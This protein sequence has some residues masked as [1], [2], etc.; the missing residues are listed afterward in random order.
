M[1]TRM[2][3]SFSAAVYKIKL[4]SPHYEEI[5]MDF[6]V[7]AHMTTV[8]DL[9]MYSYEKRLVNFRPDEMKFLHMQLVMEPKRLLSSYPI[10]VLGDTIRIIKIL[11]TGFTVDMRVSATEYSEFLKFSYPDQNSV[12]FPINGEIVLKFG[13]SAVRNIQ[14]FVPA[15]VD[16]NALL[17]SYG[18][19]MVRNLG[20]LKEAKKRGYVAW[21]D[22]TFSQRAFLLELPSDKKANS[23]TDRFRFERIR[24]TS[25]GTLNMGYRDGDIHSWQRYTTQIPLL[26]S[27]VDTEEDDS[28]T[29]NL[30]SILRMKPIEELKYNTC[31]AILLSNNVPTVPLAGC[32]GDFTGFT[33]PGTT[34]D[35]IIA[36]KTAVRSI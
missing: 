19:N 29:G 22:Q 30:I 9:M 25:A 34:E 16:K 13:P 4:I 23:V 12:D 8:Y 33:D 7:Y 35:H 17:T 27:L 14:I 11:N 31:Y 24:Y 36:F 21:T 18:G 2:S 15:L 10:D 1:K 3:Q 20:G 28:I 26:I 6:R 5:Y 32:V